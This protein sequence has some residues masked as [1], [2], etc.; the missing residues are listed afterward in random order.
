MAPI[1]NSTPPESLDPEGVVGRAAASAHETVDR[2]AEKAQESCDRLGQFC[3]DIAELP[4]DTIRTHPV[5]AVVLALSVG[6]ILGRL[7]GN[8]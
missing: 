3:S 2:A 4:R 1:E 8:R 6:Y 5:A 7:G